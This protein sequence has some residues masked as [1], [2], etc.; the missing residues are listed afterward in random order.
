MAR[1]NS[2]THM[3][4]HRDHGVYE[5]WHKP[6]FKT[7]DVSSLQNVDYPI[8]VNLDC[9]VGAYYKPNNF[10][11]AILGLPYRGCAATIGATNPTNT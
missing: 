11:K 1:I 8:I 9:N 6:E 7:A 5:G 3:I 4:F 10:A 2:G